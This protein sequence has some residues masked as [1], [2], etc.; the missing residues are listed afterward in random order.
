MYKYSS[1]KYL[2]LIIFLLTYI[3]G[4][5]L[6]ENIAGG[7]EKDFLEFTWPVILS[8]KL[9]F[10]H[11]LKN[12]GS[13]GEGSLP[14]FHII[15]AYLNPFTHNQFFFQ[16]SI[17]FISL[18][19]LIV[20]SQI[21]EKKL[22]LKKIDAI[23]YSSIFLI[24]PFFRSSAFWGITENLGW[25]F[26][27]LSIKYFNLYGRENYKG[28]II[29]IFLICFFSSLALYI[30]PYLVFFPIFIILKSLIYKDYYLFKFSSIFYLL[31]SIPGFL[32]ILL[33]DGIFKLGDD[34]IN[35]IRD[36]HNPKFILKNLIIF[37]TI[38]FLYLAPFEM[39]KNKIFSKKNIIN[40]S[41]ILF[42]LLFLN[43]LD[44]FNYLNLLSLGG[45][46]FLKINKIIFDDNL[47]F[48]LIFS[49]LGIVLI[50]NYFLIS[51][52]N[53]L[54][55]FCLLIFC[56]PKYILQEYFEPLIL[57]ALFTLFD[58][59][60]NNYKIFQKDKTVFMFCTFF[61]IYYLGSFFYRY[62]LNPIN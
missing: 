23:I 14:L 33:W 47:I 10:Y 45:G 32:L 51:K 46:A 21:I 56:F 50:F 22:K 9:D 25:L 18:I 12:Y 40:Y 27:L 54:L 62:Y 48:F 5:F 41:L 6:R 2:F 35:L 57:I 61:S 16:G 20:F 58:L 8:F 26:L 34:E 38:F 53:K 49:S 43:Y 28:R 39:F 42:I 4:F 55:F 19:N 24:L 7:A 17:T 52:K 60:K 44:I 36:Y 30:R 15:N 3:F 37:P 29:N 31:F 59:G 1:L 13:F 11:T